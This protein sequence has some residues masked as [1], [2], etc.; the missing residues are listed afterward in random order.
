MKLCLF[1][2]RRNLLHRKLF[3]KYVGQELTVKK[4]FFMD[5]NQHCN[6]SVS[7]RDIKITE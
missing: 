1:K 5:L 7:N 6:L 3:Q 4:E 2:F